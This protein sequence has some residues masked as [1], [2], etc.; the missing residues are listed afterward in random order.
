MGLDTS[1]LTGGDQDLSFA[2]SVRSNSQE[3]DESD[4]AE[5]FHQR[6]ATQ[7]DLG[8]VGGFRRSE[9]KFSQTFQVNFSTIIIF[10][11]SPQW[12]CDRGN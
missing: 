8:M 3:L 9:K 7:A 6:L 4:N 11:Y 12:H 10:K 5:F 2:I 1:Q